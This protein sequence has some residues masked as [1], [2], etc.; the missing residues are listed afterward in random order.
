[1]IKRPLISLLLLGALSWI[2]TGCQSGEKPDFISAPGVAV[3]A[4]PPVVFREIGVVEA[5]HRSRSQW[6]EAIAQMKEEA[7][8]MGANGIVVSRLRQYENASVAE[9]YTGM[10]GAYSEGS[11]SRWLKPGGSLQAM[12]ISVPN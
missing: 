2:F 8:R 1:M 9:A 12:A 11:P 4:S 7:A 6:S 10:R 5:P 3:Y